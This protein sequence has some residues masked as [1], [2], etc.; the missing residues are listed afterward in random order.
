MTDTGIQGIMLSLVTGF[1]YLF[2][3][4]ASIVLCKHY[5]SGNVKD[6]V[7]K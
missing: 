4:I 1:W 7:T 5:V 6:G 2:Q 3:G